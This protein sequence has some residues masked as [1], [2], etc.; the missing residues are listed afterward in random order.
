MRLVAN[1]E[2]IVQLILRFRLSVTIT[3][4]DDEAGI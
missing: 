4:M 1:G 2:T 3:K